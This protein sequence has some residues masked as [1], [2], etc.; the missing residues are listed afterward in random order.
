MFSNSH[1]RTRRALA[2]GAATLACAAALACA[3]RAAS[4]A[5]AAGATPAAPTPTRQTALGPASPD[6]RVPLTAAQRRWVDSVLATLSLRQRVGQMTWIWVLGDYT[7]SRER[8]FDEVRRWIVEDQVGGATMS[9]GSPIEVAEKINA[10]QRLARIPLIISSDVEPGLG[11]LEG[12]VFSHYLMRGGGA[13]VLPSNMAIGA[14][15]SEANAL[16]AG[17]IVGRES[18]AVGIHIA[19]APTVDVNN[20]PSNPVINTRS[21]GEDPQAV[22]RMAAAFVRGVQSEGVAATI[23]HFP[24]HGDTDTDS[25]L[26]LPIVQSNRARLDSVE[27]VPFRAGIQAGAALVM[28][29]HIALPAIGAD[30]TPATLRPNIMTSLLRDTLGFHGTAVTDALTMEGVGKGYPVERSSVLAVQAGADILLKPSDVRRAID[31]VVAAVERGEISPARIEAAA[32]HVLELKVRTGVAASPMVDLAALREVVGAPEHWATANAIAE[33]A[34]TLLRDRD[35]LVALPAGRPIALVTYAPET[36]L[37]AAVTLV[38]ELRAGGAPVRSFRIYPRTARSEL[39]SIA[40]QVR[41]MDR[42]VVATIVRR[43]EGEGRTVI[44]PAIAAWIDTLATREKVVVVAGGNPYVIRQFPNVSTYM[45]TYGVGDALERAA[46]R[47]LTGR[48]AIRGKAPVSLPGFFSRGDGL[49]REATRA[50]ASR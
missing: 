43:V 27:L 39:D 36:E 22:A 14:T 35:N 45:M 29:A 11:R 46:A 3:G 24:G 19:F 8:T 48:S 23:K 12:G 31:A 28:S 2:A 13:T 6:P 18:R 16:E 21:F 9:L 38:P 17:K 26:A 25:H 20:N 40:A 10:M 33:Q 47:A 5:T 50:E 30:S 37:T 41:G 49:T 4:T 34:V 7:N 15:G 42:V 32:R 1:R 44:P